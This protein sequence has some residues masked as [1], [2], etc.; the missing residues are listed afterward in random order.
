M[1]EAIRRL[2]EVTG[3]EFVSLMKE[4]TQSRQFKPLEDGI[5]IVGT[6]EER[7]KDQDWNNLL[8]CAQ[9]AVSH[10]YEIFMLP[11]PRKT[12]SA[13]YIMVRKGLYKLADLKSVVGQNSVAARLSASAGQA[14]RAVLNMTSNYNPRR[15]GMA[16]KH[17]FDNPE[18]AEVIIFKGK[19]EISI[20][21]DVISN[22]FIKNFIRIY[23]Q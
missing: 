22:D 19:R 8:S 1:G 15:L 10:G 16:I 14:N 6:R 17:Y 4:I 9:K 2:Q 18:S 7:E 5:W 11:N 20:R 23:T 12:K 3:S 13:D 21:R